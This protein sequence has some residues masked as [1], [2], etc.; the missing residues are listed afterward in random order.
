MTG[1]RHTDWYRRGAST[2]LGIGLLLAYLFV[3]IPTALTAVPL[4]I[5]ETPAVTVEPTL[6]GTLTPALPGTL[7]LTP[8][9]AL[10]GFDL[11]RFS[12]TES[13]WETT[14]TGI[15]HKP[16]GD[17]PY[18]AVL[19]SHGK[20]GLA[21]GFSLV[22]AQTWFSDYI[23]IAPNYTHAANGIG[24]TGPQG[25]SPE[26]VK[27]A[28]RCLDI[29]ESQDLIDQIGD[30]VDQD[31]LYLYGNSMGGFVTIEAAAQAGG[32][33]QAAAYTASGLALTD[34][35]LTPSGAAAAA[36]I[37][38]PF[39]MLHGQ[40]DGTMTPAASQAWAD[41]LTDYDKPF[42]LVWFPEIGHDLNAN[43]LTAAQV[44][45]FHP[46]LVQP[47]RTPNYCPLSVHR[48]AGRYSYDK[49]FAFWNQ[50]EQQQ[51]DPFQRSDRFAPALD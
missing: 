32:R 9:Y 28:M 39:L 14:L 19:I 17:G 50:S 4:D 35:E 34:P 33:I 10:P 47:A 21:E 8:L 20:G 5:T 40:Q 6:I 48:L 44:A 16:E 43:P 49:R 26:N 1:N 25:G 29:L 2:L 11:W 45:Q 24:G 27:R 15:I 12:Y 3:S 38:A 23:S 31:R 18:P 46:R 41:A 22:K 30:A 37:Q 42:Q 7:T 36:T 51:P 13:G